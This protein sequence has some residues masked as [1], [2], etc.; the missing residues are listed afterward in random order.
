MLE[1]LFNKVV[2]SFIIKET[3][4]QTHSRKFCEILRKIYFEE[5][6]ELEGLKKKIV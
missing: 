3:P 1:S 5:L 2:G 6:E 4:A